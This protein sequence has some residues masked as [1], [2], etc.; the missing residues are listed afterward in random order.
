[1]KFQGPPHFL[2]TCI[3]NN[4]PAM[5]GSLGNVLMSKG[6]RNVDNGH[7]D[8]TQP[9]ERVYIWVTWARVTNENVKNNHNI[10]Y[11]NK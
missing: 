1:M 5:P 9:P 10:S 4:K 6:A 7:F 11:E 3:K 8:I 2:M